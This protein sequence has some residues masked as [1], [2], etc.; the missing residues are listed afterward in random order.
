MNT[1]VALVLCAGL[2]CATASDSAQAPL[3]MT[4]LGPVVG[5]RLTERG[6]VVDAYLG[7]PFAEP[8]VGERRFLKP[9]AAEPWTGVFNATSQNKGCVQTDM[10]ITPTVSFD[11]SETTED[12]LYLNVWVPE[13]A[14]DNKAKDPCDK[15]LPVFV[16]LYGGFFGWGST[17]L[18]VFDG[19]HFASRSKLIV[20]TFNYRVNVFGFLN[21]SS[22]VA[23]GNMGLY[24]QLEAL[25]WIRDNVQAFGGDP[26]MVT[27]GGQSAGAISA[28]YHM[29]SD[30][31]KGL[32]KRAAL[33]SGTPSTI[34]YSYFIDQLENIRSISHFSSRT[35]L[36]FVSFNFRVGV[37]GFL[38]SSSSEAPGNMGLY[39][40][41]EVLRWI[42]KNI[43]L[44]G[45]D[46]TAV[47]LAGEIA[48][49]IS[50]SYHLMSKL[51]EGFFKRAAIMSGTPLTV[52]FTEG[53]DHHETF[54]RTAQ[55]FNCFDFYAPW[56]SQISK[57]LNCLPQVNTHEIYRK[58]EKELNFRYINLLPNYGDKFL[59]SWP[60]D[61]DNAKTSAKDVLIGTVLNDGV[62][63]VQQLFKQVP[64]AGLIDG[65]T[66]FI[67]M[68]RTLYGVALHL[69]AR[70]AKEHFR[71][72]N[73]ADLLLTSQLLSA[74]TADAGLDCAADEF[75]LAA[76]R[77]GARVFR[78]LFARR[79]SYSR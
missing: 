7:I 40:L 10:P 34:A 16:F 36:I 27:I 2:A 32:F 69:G 67:S 23:P 15:L 25:R 5:T 3:V 59:P 72:R 30:L 22:P 31:S 14:C 56:Q 45:E 20:I 57:I 37:L 71:N 60:T 58:M 79:P 63:L 13:R 19:V 66:L 38:N 24:D 17:S 50:V 35:G 1:G 76:V 18:F 6:S 54:R 73:S 8:P 61:T 68:L 21:A 47:T 9:V 42:K 55:F 77:N 39:D 49:A 64:W 12:C 78:Y 44:F 75:G 62:Y 74:A 70:L 65:R 46:P 28:S 11:M 33:L 29:M 43:Q 4:R 52:A 41:V 51:N 48:L 53:L 26:D